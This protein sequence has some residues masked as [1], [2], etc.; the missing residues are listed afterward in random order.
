MDKHRYRRRARESVFT[1]SVLLKRFYM[2]KAGL[3]K[4]IALIKEYLQFIRASKALY[5]KD[6]R[7][8]RK[9]VNCA[10]E[11]SGDMLEK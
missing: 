2:D 8:L 4:G 11:D 9:A 3:M 7:K 6:Y 10:G 5:H 1:L